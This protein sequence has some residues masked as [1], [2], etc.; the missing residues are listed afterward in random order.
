M[1]QTTAIERIKQDAVK[2]LYEK[3]RASSLTLELKNEM[4]EKSGKTTEQ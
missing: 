4:I 3:L 1:A 2:E